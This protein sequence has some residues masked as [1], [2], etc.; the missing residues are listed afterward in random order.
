MDDPELAIIIC[1]QTLS[2]YATYFAQVVELTSRFLIIL[3][4]AT[5]FLEHL[6]ERTFFMPF[7][8]TMTAICSQFYVAGK[9]L[10]EAISATN[11]ATMSFRDLI[12]KERSTSSSLSQALSNQCD[13]VGNKTTEDLITPVKRR[14]H[15]VYDV[16][17]WNSLVLNSMKPLVP[18]ETQIQ[19]QEE[20][21]ISA[22]REIM[23][24]IDN[25]MKKVK[26]EPSTSSLIGQQNLQMVKKVEEVCKS[27]SPMSNQQQ[28][29]TQKKFVDNAIVKKASI[30]NIII[31]NESDSK[32]H[33]KKRKRKRTP[34][35]QDHQQEKP[36]IQQQNRK[37]LKDF[38][39]ILSM[40]S[41]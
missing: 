5:G 40:L 21:H 32:P 30:P 10:H 35:Q 2:T 41:S 13:C 8:L 36:N 16:A 18:I 37:E 33:P 12:L 15:T 26:Q 24:K 34:S 27:P 20:Q 23:E 25:P 28:K 6:L 17:A 39:N 11:T 9:S 3:E 29:R 4:K 1:P 22:C 38:K 19:S 14:P 31:P 7:A